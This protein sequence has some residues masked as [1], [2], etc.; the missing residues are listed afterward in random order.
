MLR[1]NIIRELMSTFPSVDRLQINRIVRH[2]EAEGIM[3]W[4]DEHDI[5]VTD[6]AERI[7]TMYNLKGILPHAETRPPTD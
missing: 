7:I 1:H 5:P 6:V 4:A 3:D 2:A